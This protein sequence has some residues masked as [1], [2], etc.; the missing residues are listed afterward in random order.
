M[1]APSRVAEGRRALRVSHPRGHARPA[2]YA[3]AI[4]ILRRA[5]H[6][7]GQSRMLP[8][9]SETIAFAE[10]IALAG[11]E[12]IGKFVGRFPVTDDVEP[13][14]AWRRRGARTTRL[15]RSSG[16][17]ILMRN[18]RHIGERIISI[19]SS[20]S[21]PGSRAPYSLVLA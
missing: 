3:V 9:R 10:S 6:T 8:P 16:M 5:A 15:R 2:C 1:R 21:I 18:A 20:G 19:G 13:L 11:C 17:S 14:R 12:R 4:V 7:A